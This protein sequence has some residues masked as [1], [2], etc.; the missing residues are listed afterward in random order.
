MSA[1]YGTICGASKQ[2]QAKNHPFPDNS[3]NLLGT[4]H[5]PSDLRF[6]RQAGLTAFSLAG[7][8]REAGE[9]LVLSSI[10]AAETSGYERQNVRG[11]MPGC[12]W[13]FLQLN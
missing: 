7:A 5:R 6:E 9:D 3:I 2:I 13:P 12:C 11:S 10:E 1:L 4:Y 8:S